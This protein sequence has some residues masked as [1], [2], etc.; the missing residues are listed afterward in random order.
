M[1]ISNA[2]NLQHFFSAGRVVKIYIIKKEII[3]NAPAER[4]FSALTNSVE[5]PRFYP[6]KSVVSTWKVGSEVLY[7]GEING[8]PFT[9]YGVIERL[10]S[11]RVYSYRYWSNNH[12][13]ERVDENFI[14][15][16]YD[17][18]SVGKTTRLTMFQSNIKSLEL[19]ELMNTQVWEFLL[20]SLKK[21]LEV[22]T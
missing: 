13:T 17:V 8:T 21:Y 3:I 15:I 18:E 10:Y 6:L 5:I 12:G 14:S 16:N 1:E 20:G 11:P 22:R 9:D 4:V 19:Y 7:N 2:C